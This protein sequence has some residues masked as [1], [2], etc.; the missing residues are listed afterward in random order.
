MKH[1]ILKLNDD[2]LS[3]SSRTNKLLINSDETSKTISDGVEAFSH[4]AYNLEER[5]KEFSNRELVV[6][7]AD[8][9]ERVLMLAEN[10]STSDATVQKVLMFLGEWV[11]AIS[12]TFEDID[13]KTDE[14]SN[15]SDA[16]SELRKIVPE[17]GDLFEKLEEAFEEQQSRIDRLED[18]I[19]KLKEIVEMNGISPVLQRIEKLENIVETMNKNVEKLTSYV[20]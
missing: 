17:K 1:G 14:I 16:L 12:E 19:N 2:I 15:I 20:E 11:D 10:S 6:Q 5:I 8:K 18:K 13:N 7:I 3:I 4:I 9:V